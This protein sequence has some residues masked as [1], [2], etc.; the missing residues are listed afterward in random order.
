[1]ADLTY[2]TFDLISEFWLIKVGLSTVSVNVFVKAFASYRLN[3]FNFFYMQINIIEYLF[4][5]V[6]V[7]ALLLQ[8]RPQRA[9]FSGQS[10][11]GGRM[12]LTGYVIHDLV[13]IHHKH[14]EKHQNT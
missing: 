1:M 12:V 9:S 14:C 8:Q 7:H 11:C 5:S 6:C 2:C 3:I 10:E 13:L 4:F